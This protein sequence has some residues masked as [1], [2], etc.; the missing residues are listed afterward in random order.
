MS[1]RSPLPA[2]ATWPVPTARTAGSFRDYVLARPYDYGRGSPG[3]WRFIAE[4][5]GERDLPDARSWAELR[6]YLEA[7]QASGETLR[8]ARSVWRSFTAR[9]SRLRARHPAGG[10]E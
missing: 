4:L 9:R 6:A 1:D 10:P 3:A 2:A 7:R 5:R 8:A